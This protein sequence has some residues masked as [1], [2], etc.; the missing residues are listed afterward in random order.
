MMEQPASAPG[1]WGF[2]PGTLGVL[3]LAKKRGLLDAVTPVL[4]RLRKQVFFGYDGTHRNG[5]TL[6][7]E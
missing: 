5:K 1:F 4:M 6:G 2:L 3:V 7:G